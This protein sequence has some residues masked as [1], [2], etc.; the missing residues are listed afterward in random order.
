MKY[1]EELASKR[2][3]KRH[4]SKLDIVLVLLRF[5]YPLILAI[6]A[7]IVL[8]QCMSL[9]SN[10]EIAGD[11]AVLFLILT[12]LKSVGTAL[13]CVVI[14]FTFLFVIWMIHR[15]RQHNYRIAAILSDLVALGMITFTVLLAFVYIFVI[16][17]SYANRQKDNI[18]L[19]DQIF[20]LLG[21]NTYDDLGY[22]R[23]VLYRCDSQGYS[24]SEIYE[25]NWDYDTSQPAKLAYNSN[26]Q[27]VSV[28]IDGEVLYTHQLE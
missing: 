10:V 6:I 14:P 9:I 25:T 19:N 23:F 11:S 12:G 21:R 1:W 15:E 8:L 18:V 26:A 22:G 20:S 2:K 3:N 4:T 24:C 28:I 7:F 27:K 5:H 17:T 16:S 13:S